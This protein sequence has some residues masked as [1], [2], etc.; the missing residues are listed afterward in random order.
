MV[1]CGLDSADPRWDFVV[2]SCEHGN[3]TSDEFLTS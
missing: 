3:E 1:R 2:G